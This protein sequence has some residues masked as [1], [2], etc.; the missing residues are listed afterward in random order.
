MENSQMKILSLDL[1]TKTG[2]AILAGPP[3]CTPDSGVQT[4]DVR[5]G[6]SPGMRYHRFRAWL[7]EM[8]F[9]FDAGDIVIYEQA[10]NRGG[11]A[12]QLL[13]GMT[14]I[15]F[16]ECAV[17]GV[18]HDTIHSST[19]KKWATG[20]GRAEKQAMIE[21]ARRRGGTPRDDNE[22]DA[23]LILCYARERY[24]TASRRKKPGRGKSC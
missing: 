5:R 16:E 9:M 23:W 12:T 3:P 18:D 15:I 20:S 6:E 1:G 4:F 10:H 22:A 21:A 13:N 19:L 2:W 11:A 8:M 14:A 24:L 17:A 7:R